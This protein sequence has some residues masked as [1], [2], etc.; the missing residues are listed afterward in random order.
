MIRRGAPLLIAGAGALWAREKMRAAAPPPA[1]FPAPEAPPVQEEPPPVE[2]D[3]PEPQGRFAREE[4]PAEP[5][6][7]QAET[8]ENAAL[9][10][11]TPAAP[12]SRE[13]EAGAEAG[14]P[15]EGPPGIADVTEVVDDLLLGRS[16]AAGDEQIE[17][18]TVVEE[19]HPE[20][21]PISRWD[22]GS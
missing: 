18:A 21:P 14:A 20:P 7:D 10:A 22:D 2:E 3:A 9:V 6:A 16:S 8:V 11:A 4:P 15:Q 13:E 19:P 17:D 1:D 5:E 12:P